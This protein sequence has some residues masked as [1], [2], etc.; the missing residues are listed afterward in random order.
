MDSTPRNFSAFL[1]ELGTC[2]FNTLTA[3]NHLPLGVTIIEL[4]RRLIVEGC[5]RHTWYFLEIQLRF[6]IEQGYVEQN[7]ETYRPT[8]PIADFLDGLQMNWE[9]TVARLGQDRPIKSEQIETTT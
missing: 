2:G 7:G 9:Q 3:L 1:Q 6:M 8:Q 5:P 4:Q